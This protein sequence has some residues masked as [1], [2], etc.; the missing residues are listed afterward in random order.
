MDIF[1]FC[2]NDHRICGQPEYMMCGTYERSPTAIPWN[3]TF[4]AA[5]DSRFPEIDVLEGVPQ[6]PIV[7]EFMC[8]LVVSNTT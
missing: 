1:E 4:K 6:I 8:L 5:L 7:V 2:T 3:F